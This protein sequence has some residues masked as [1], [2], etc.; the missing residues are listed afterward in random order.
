VDLQT[1]EDMPF[2]KFLLRISN[3]YYQTIGKYTKTLLTGT[4]E[5]TQHQRPPS[6]RQFMQKYKRK[7]QLH[8]VKNQKSGKKQRVSLEIMTIPEEM[9]SRCISTRRIGRASKRSDYQQAAPKELLED[10]EFEGPKQ[11]QPVRLTE[12]D[13]GNRECVT[14]QH[15]QS[16]MTL[17]EDQLS[18]SEEKDL[19]Q[20]RPDMQEAIKPMKRS[21]SFD[22]LF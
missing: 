6:K 14:S 13:M 9:T 15:K 5:E 1:V 16:Q 4:K 17:R 22:E 7:Q 11:Q 21:H 2:S 10:M 19:D 3:S 20:G 12:V 18:P 8:S